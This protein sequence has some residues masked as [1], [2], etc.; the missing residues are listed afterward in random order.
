MRITPSPH[1]YDFMKTT[2][3]STL[4]EF[5]LI[6]RLT[7]DLPAPHASTLRGVGDDCAVISH[8][9][10]RT[11]VTSDMLMEGIHFD[12]VYTP[13]K[14][15]G[16]KAAMVNFSD[17]YAMGGTPRQLLVNLAVSG[18]FGVEQ[19]DE[20]YGGIRFACARCNVDIVGGDTTS[21]LT[22]L[23]LSLT[24]LGE[25]RDED[26]VYR[27]GAHDT[28]LICVSGNSARPIWDCN[29]SSAKRKSSQPNAPMRAK[30]RSPTLADGSI[31][32]SASSSPRHGAT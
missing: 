16:Y 11:L 14:H 8:A 29:C 7:A 5:G 3:L 31:S 6:D 12:L 28:D 15:L 2:P 1:Q 23:A 13:L 19:L 24:C 25:A 4:G 32:S 18:R 9:P 21:S 20:L 17:V 26:I 27:S 22:G 10:L 30:R